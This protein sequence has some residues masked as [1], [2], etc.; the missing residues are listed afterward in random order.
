MWGQ[1]SLTDCVF[2]ERSDGALAI[3]AEADDACELDLAPPVSLEDSSLTVHFRQLPEDP[4]A[5]TSLALF[6]GESKLTM[7]L[8]G[9]SLESS[10]EV[11][12]GEPIEADAALSSPDQ[13]LLWRVS[14]TS[15]G[16]GL[17]LVRF[18]YSADG[19]LWSQLDESVLP[20]SAA[21]LDA[22]VG[23][24][25]GTLEIEALN[26]PTAASERGSAVA[27]RPR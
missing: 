16:A 10:I 24:E 27:E 5:I 20:F 6:R 2:D 23:V 21:E 26:P 25:A 22:R 12:G 14:A 1:T 7:T 19:E 9:G 3:A 11:E 15:G 4:S 17:S 13:A 8:Q 18:E